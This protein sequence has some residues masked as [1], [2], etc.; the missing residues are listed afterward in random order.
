MEVAITGELNILYIVIH[1]VQNTIKWRQNITPMMEEIKMAYLVYYEHL[2]RINGGW[3]ECYTPYTN[4][5]EVV[6]DAKELK[7]SSNPE[8]R[9]LLFYKP[10]IR[11]ITILEATEI[12][13]WDNMEVVDSKPIPMRRQ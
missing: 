11:G 10:Q 13:D 6:K 4:L 12:K 5:A 9:S 8:I 7:A 3:E 1:G 2:N